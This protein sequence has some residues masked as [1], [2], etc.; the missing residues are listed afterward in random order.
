MLPTSVAVEVYNNIAAS[1]DGPH[2]TQVGQDGRDGPEDGREDHPGPEHGRDGPE[3]GPEDH[4]R[5]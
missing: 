3:D 2:T 1:Q 5:P 4:P